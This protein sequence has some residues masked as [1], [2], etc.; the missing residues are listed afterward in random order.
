VG[1]LKR[2]A[3][4]SAGCLHLN[5][6]AGAG[7]GLMDV[8]RGLFGPQPPGDVAAMADL[9]IRCHKRDLAFSLE[10][11]A[12]LAMQCCLVGLDRQEE[13]GSLLLELPKNGRWVLSATA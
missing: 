7:P 1:G 3:V 2:L 10:L 13:V 6:P 12:D 5:D 11:A 9:V 8:L 4:A